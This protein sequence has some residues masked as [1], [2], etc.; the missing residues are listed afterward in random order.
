MSDKELKEAPRAN[1]LEVADAVDMV[2][3]AL[4]VGLVPDAVTV[5]SVSVTE[6][7]LL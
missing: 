3:V 5:F 2:C 6:A 4:A 7:E 1:R